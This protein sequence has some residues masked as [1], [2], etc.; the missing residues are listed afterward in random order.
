[1]QQISGTHQS[2]EKALLILLAFESENREIGTIELSQM[3]GFHK[4]TVSRLLKV[5]MAY[6][7]LQQ[8]PETKKFSLG[9]AVVHLA[10]ALNQSLKT[11]LVQI[12][13]PHID[14]LKYS[15]KETVILEVLAGENMVM[16]YVAE[17]PRRVRLAGSIG[18]RV[19]FHAA[20]GAKAFLAFCPPELRETL[21]GVKLR[22][23]TK[24]TITDREKLY[25]QLE[26]IR[27]NG[28]A[29]DREEIDEGTCAVG[30]AVFNHEKEPVASVV[31]A[32]P[33]QRITWNSDSPMVSA[34][35]DTAER[36]SA[37]LYFKQAATDPGSREA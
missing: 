21:I 11:N 12:A 18:D 25:G 14:K 6:D 15:L 17:G 10:H 3:L 2:L 34:L 5:L 9:P 31:V 8:N 19:P 29:F 26:E 36:I 27:K 7:F 1:V 33:P 24:Y 16:V 37:Q 28:F 22:R 23:F 35:K 4:S 30:A 13:K 32:G 20:A